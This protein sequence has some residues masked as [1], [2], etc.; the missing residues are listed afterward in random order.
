MEAIGVLSVFESIG[1][2]DYCNKV[3]ISYNTKI[4]LEI[5]FVTL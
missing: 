2:I 5:L 1:E 4:E 3:F